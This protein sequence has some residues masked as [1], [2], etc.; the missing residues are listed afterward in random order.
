MQKTTKTDENT[1]HKSPI[2]LKNKINLKFL[3]LK[4]IGLYPTTEIQKRKIL[5]IFLNSEEIFEF[6]KKETDSDKI[7]EFL[8]REHG[9][10]VKGDIGDGIEDYF[11]DLEMDLI[12][13]VI[14]RF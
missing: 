10:D 2:T 12:M 14:D 9:V 3:I 11:V 13:D 4:E 8:L 1:I 6:I 5:H 7:K